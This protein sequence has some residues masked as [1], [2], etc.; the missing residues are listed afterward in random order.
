MNYFIG[1]KFGVPVK[2]FSKYA[3]PTT[4]E[5]LLIY[6]DETTFSTVLSTGELWGFKKINSYYELI[7]YSSKGTSGARYPV[8]SNYCH[9]AYCNAQN[10][11]QRIGYANSDTVEKSPPAA[12]LIID[13]KTIELSAETIAELK[14]KRGV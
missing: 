4:Q 3:H 12:T 11:M 6:E 14:K 9:T 1:W 2:V 7:P 5:V 10:V 8:C 13:G